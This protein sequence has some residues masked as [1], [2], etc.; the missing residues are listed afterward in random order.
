MRDKM[1]G[2]QRTG[3]AVRTCKMLM[4]KPQWNKTVGKRRHNWEGAIN[5]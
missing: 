1:D 3:E 4:L 2:L 5:L